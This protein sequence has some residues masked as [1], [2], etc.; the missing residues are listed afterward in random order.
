M[1]L[2]EIPGLTKWMHESGMPFLARL[3]T[4]N[5]W[6][7]SAKATAFFARFD[8]A[9]YDKARVRRDG[10][11]DTLKLQVKVLRRRDWPLIE[12][13][14]R[15]AFPERRIGTVRRRRLAQ[16]TAMKARALIG[17]K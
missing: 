2:R 10:T 6:T 14:I 7:R 17:S 12:T 5:K 9:K 8:D 3:H 15:L 13:Y 1:Y 4:Q 11:E 16:P